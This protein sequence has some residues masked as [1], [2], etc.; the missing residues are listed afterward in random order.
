[1]RRRDRA[2]CVALFLLVFPSFLYGQSSSS[3]P[4]S[5]AKTVGKLRVEN[6]DEIV[7]SGGDV[8]PQKG[9]ASTAVHGSFR[10]F[11]GLFQRSTNTRESQVFDSDHFPGVQRNN[12][13]A[14]YALYRDALEKNNIKLGAPFDSDAYFCDD[15]SGQ[16]K[17][18]RK[19]QTDTKRV[20][21]NRD[22]RA[23]NY[24]I[25]ISEGQEWE[26]RFIDMEQCEIMDSSFVQG[27][28]KSRGDCRTIRKEVDSDAVR[29]FPC[30]GIKNKMSRRQNQAVR[31][32]N[33]TTSFHVCVDL[34][35]GRI[36]LPANIDL[37]HWFV[38]FIVSSGGT[39]SQK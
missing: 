36:E 13:C 7:N 23:I 8:D 27:S 24:F 15:S 25:L 14:G 37:T 20:S 1:M 10:I 39:E 33:E 29:S 31:G 2:S 35:N 34:D 21:D 16:A 5:S 6:A 17:L 4:V 30:V 9:D 32:H 28:H 22:G 11:L 38:G 18:Y 26:I 19:G 3:N 12:G